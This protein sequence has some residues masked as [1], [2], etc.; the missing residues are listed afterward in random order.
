M[1]VSILRHGVCYK[2]RMVIRCQNCACIAV[3]KGIDE[4]AVKCPECFHE[5]DVVFLD[6]EEFNQLKE[7]LKEEE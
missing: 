7:E 3:F 6:D 2:S 5:N 1:S 4:C